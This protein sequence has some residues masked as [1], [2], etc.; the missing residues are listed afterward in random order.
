MRAV[1][2]TW[3]NSYHALSLLGNLSTHLVENYNGQ[4]N[5]VINNTISKVREHLSLLKSCHANTGAFVKYTWDTA[6]AKD[7]ESFS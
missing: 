5:P 2:S 4:A 7:L 6:Q 3:R 1:A